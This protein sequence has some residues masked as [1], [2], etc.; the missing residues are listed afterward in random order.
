MDQSIKTSP[1]LCASGDSFFGLLSTFPPIFTMFTPTQNLNNSHRQEW[2]AS[3]VCSNIITRNV[4]TI[5]DSTEVDQ[6]LNRNTDRRWKHSDELVP[7]WAVAGVNPKTGE[8]SFKGAQFKPDKAP[9]DPETQKP[10]KYFSPSRSPLSPLFLEMPDSDYWSKLLFDF[11]T[12]IVLT[13]G[14][15]KAG[16]VLSKGTPCISIPGVSTGGKLGRLRPELELYCRY[17]R[18]IY[19]AFDR[20]I[21]TKKTVQQALHNL[22]RMIAAN[23]AM[24]YVL[25]WNNLYK[26]IDDYLAAGGEL[27]PRIYEAKTLEEWRDEQE[28]SPTELLEVETCR[29]ALRYKMV[30]DKLRGRLRWN[31]L[32]G[33]IELDGQPADVDELRLYL[34]LKHNIDIPV[35]DCCQIVTYIGL[36]EKVFYEFLEG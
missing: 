32:K 28:N 17:G 13:E 12:P 26:G 22:A 35:E 23:G 20:D 7:G 14:A 8:R 27:L 33:E 4:W 3:G 34:A 36:A 15:K 9:I 29:L 25:E 16:A 19:L 6:L 18:R 21:I 30:H 11:T 10:R 5:E 2:E 1:D 24:V 31:E